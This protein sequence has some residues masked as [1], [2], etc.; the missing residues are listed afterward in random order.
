MS[1]VAAS[2]RIQSGL[3]NR[4]D[5]F[6]A[7]H[8]MMCFVL[9]V[10]TT[11]VYRGTTKCIEQPIVVKERLD[12]GFLF[13]SVHRRC[14]EL[15]FSLWLHV[16]IRKVLL[17]SCMVI[18]ETLNAARYCL[19]RARFGS[20]PRRCSATRRPRRCR[21]DGVAVA[22]VGAGAGASRGAGHRVLARVAAVPPG[23]LEV[24]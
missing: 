15:T 23:R 21:S 22:A 7:V 12:T 20:F 24:L 19:R 2:V 10:S 8:T 13:L 1:V 16:L 9:R 5:I 14:V 3:K 18:E 4:L 6:L 17:H 11:F